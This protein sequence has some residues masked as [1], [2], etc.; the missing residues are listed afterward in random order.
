MPVIEVPYNG[1]SR[2][3]SRHNAKIFLNKA[4]M[5]VPGVGGKSCYVY[6]Y[7]R[8]EFR[9]ETFDENYL[10]SDQFKQVCEAYPPT[11]VSKQANHEMVIH[12]SGCPP[13]WH[14]GQIFMEMSS[15]DCS[16]MGV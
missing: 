12:L 13:E 7:P 11:R 5:M 9:T 4:F 16:P 8:V 10:S 1:G 6:K 2:I 15:E 14:S 3:P